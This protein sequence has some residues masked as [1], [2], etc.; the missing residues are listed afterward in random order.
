MLYLITTSNNYI[1]I[2][3]RLV[4]RHGAETMSLTRGKEEK[5]RF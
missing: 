1:Q 4:A 3:I 2:A 5:L